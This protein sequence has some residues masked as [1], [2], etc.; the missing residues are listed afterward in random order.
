MFMPFR[1][2]CFALVRVSEDLRAAKQ[3]EDPA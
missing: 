3:T 1:N 2:L